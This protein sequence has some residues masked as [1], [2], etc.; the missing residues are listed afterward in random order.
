M[1]SEQ[2]DSKHLTPRQIINRYRKGLY[3]DESMEAISSVISSCG[4]TFNSVAVPIPTTLVE[5]VIDNIPVIQTLY[6]RQVAGF[7]VE[8][9]VIED[10]PLLKEVLVDLSFPALWDSLKANG[11]ELE[12]ESVIV[13]RGLVHKYHEEGL[14]A[15]VTQV[16][17]C[18][19][20]IY[21]DN[22]KSAGLSCEKLGK[23]LST[24]MV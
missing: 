9:V 7:S 15:P 8:G 11:N 20:S 17:D 18:Y 16:V 10:Y 1:M 19:T 24:M 4:E 12:Y 14:T 3:V 13:E 6:E 2:N 22:I 23:A 21:E 5:K